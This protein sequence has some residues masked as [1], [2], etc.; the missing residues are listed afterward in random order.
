MCLMK[1]VHANSNYG[2]VQKGFEYPVMSEDRD[3]YRIKCQGKP[4]YI[5]KSITGKPMRRERVEVIDD[6]EEFNGEE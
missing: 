3:F 4:I 2:P 1:T 6:Y 5:P